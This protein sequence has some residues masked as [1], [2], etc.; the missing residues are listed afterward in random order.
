MKRGLD[1]AISSEAVITFIVVLASQ[2]VGLGL[3][4]KTQGYTNL[5]YSLASLAAYTVSFVAMARL[6][7][8]GTGLAILIP[9]LAATIPLVSVAIGVL[10]Y[11]ESASLPK[12]GIL[13]AACALIG[14]A[15]RF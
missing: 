8:S 1:M 4:P 3:L 15:S 6:I 11:G 13:L 12:V 10:A 7:R 2:L 14:V 9:A 5:G